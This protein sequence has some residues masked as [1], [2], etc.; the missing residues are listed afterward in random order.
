MQHISLE[1]AKKLHSL[2]WT[3]ETSFAYSLD[4]EG[5]WSHPVWTGGYDWSDYPFYAGGVEVVFAPLAE[6]LLEVLPLD[7]G[8][9]SLLIGRDDSEVTASYEGLTYEMVH[10]NLAEALALLLIELVEQGVVSKDALQSKQ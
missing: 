3:R 2:G 4:K 10:E 8:Q 6:E 7:F 5:H 1:T 9:G